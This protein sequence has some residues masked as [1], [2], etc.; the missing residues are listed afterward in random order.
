MK[1]KEKQMDCRKLTLGAMLV[2]AAVF[3]PLIFASAEEAEPQPQAAPQQAQPPSI[4]PAGPALWQHLQQE[5]YRERWEMWPGKSAFY[6]GTEP[7][8]VLLTTYVNATAYDAITEKEAPLPPGSV[9]VKENYDQAKTLQSYTVMLKSEGFNPEAGNWFW[10]K[11]TAAGEV[12]AAGK[13]DGCIQCHG[14]KEENDYIMTSPL[15]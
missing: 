2:L 8:G 4:E 3:F 12:E 1:R 15:K 10:A 9:I 13:A 14:T 6:A 11:Y 7:H 5:N